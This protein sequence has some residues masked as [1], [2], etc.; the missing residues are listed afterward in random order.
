M[1]TAYSLA[2]ALLLAESP[3]LSG[4]VIDLGMGGAHQ[5]VDLLKTRNVPYIF[6]LAP[7]ER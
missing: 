3:A 6:D 4:A 7:A 5:I 2:R 1:L